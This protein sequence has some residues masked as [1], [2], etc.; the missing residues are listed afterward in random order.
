M[1][2]IVID[3]LPIFGMVGEKVDDQGAEKVYIYTHKKFTFTY[4]QDRVLY[5]FGNT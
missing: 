3:D 2:I 4:N 1:L 5:Q